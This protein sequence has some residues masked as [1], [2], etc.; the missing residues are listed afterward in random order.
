MYR[1]SSEAQL[2][3]ETML[4]SHG[5]IY[6]KISL[7]DTCLYV[8]AQFN[9]EWALDAGKWL[10]RHTVLCLLDLHRP[11][12]YH[13]IMNTGI[14]IDNTY[15]RTILEHMYLLC[16]LTTILA[17]M[18][19]F[20]SP[21]LHLGKHGWTRSRECLCNVSSIGRR[22]YLYNVFTHWLTHLPLEKWPPFRRRYFLMNFLERKVLYFD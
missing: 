18:I 6:N 19:S 4:S 1:F 8:M 10:K 13:L 22:L 21:P 17:I 12:L 11:S 14:P 2:Y 20:P 15:K 7:W 9:W 16:K 5:A 3:D